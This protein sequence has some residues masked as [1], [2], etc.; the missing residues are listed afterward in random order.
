[1]KKH[2]ILFLLCWITYFFTY[3]GRQN[4]T[5]SMSEIIAAEGYITL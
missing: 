1:M 2:C 4:C 3:I 5:A